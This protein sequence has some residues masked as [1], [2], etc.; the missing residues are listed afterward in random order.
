MLFRSVDSFGTDA[1]TINRTLENIKNVD[2]DSP[3]DDPDPSNP[4][5]AI[6][7]ADKR[8]VS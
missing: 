8:K 5:T 7:T 3:L 2:D 1:R 4:M 6:G